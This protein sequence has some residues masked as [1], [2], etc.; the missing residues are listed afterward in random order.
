MTLIDKDH[1]ATDGRGDQ[2][3]SAD[4]PTIQ[5]Q[6]GPIRFGRAENPAAGRTQDARLMKAVPNSLKN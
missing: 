6:P 5:E 4:F 3:N 1:A 2:T